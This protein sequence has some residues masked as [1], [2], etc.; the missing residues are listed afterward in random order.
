MPPNRTIQFWGEAHVTTITGSNLTPNNLQQLKTVKVAG[1]HTIT[2]KIA[3][4]MLAHAGT[5]LVPAS[6]FTR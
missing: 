4:G 6:L 5:R 3:W 2:Q 1:I